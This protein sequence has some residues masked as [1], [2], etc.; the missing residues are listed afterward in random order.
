[1][2]KRRKR[3]WEVGK[4]RR[5]RALNSAVGPFLDR[6]DAVSEVVRGPGS[7]KWDD[8]FVL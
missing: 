6:D 1:M 2:G 8:K 4:V 5:K 3:F 7:F